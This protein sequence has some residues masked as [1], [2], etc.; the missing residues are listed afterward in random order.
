[1]KKLLLFSAFLLSF[2]ILAQNKPG[3]TEN[4]FSVSF[5]LPGVEYETSL[6]NKTTVDL[7][8]GTGFTFAM[9]KSIGT[10]FGVYP[11]FH[12]QYRYY[13]NF[14]KRAEKGKNIHNNSGNYFALSGGLYGGKPLVGEIE[15]QMDYGAEVGPVWGLQRVYGSGFKLDLHLG[16]GYSFNDLGESGFSSLIS[17]RLGWLI[18]D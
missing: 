16:L 17:F 6:S 10:E 5:L 7:R 14:K 15:Y 11:N 9:G 12:T 4:Q 2:S 3:T 13:Y 18:F 1:M 8:A